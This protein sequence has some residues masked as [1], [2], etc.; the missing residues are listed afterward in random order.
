MIIP[1]KIPVAT[2]GMSVLAAML[3][4]GYQT[5]LGEWADSR[6]VG[7]FQLR[8]EFPL[9][10]ENGKQ[11]LE[12][13]G[14]LQQDVETLLNLKAGTNP[15]EVNL[16]RTRE[17][18]RDYLSQ[19]VPEG[20]SRP[21]LFVKSNDIGRVYVYRHWGFEKDVRHECTHAVLHNAL[22]YV[23]L[24]IDEG[25]AEYFEVPRSDRN[26]G[27]PHLSELKRRVYF[28]W[29]PDLQKLE[30]L[31]SLQD[32]D[33]DDYRDSW[34]V[35]HFLLHGPQEVRQILADYLYDIQAG[36]LAGKLSDRLNARVP[37]FDA[38]VTAHIR[39]WK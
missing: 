15:I 11:L 5:A 22:P 39:H 23:P 27:N 38:H 32:M 34:A 35:V 10:D 19:R 13:M 31:G 21:A 7:P 36:N 30:T 17:N 9:S 12:E 4:L 33:A 1:L 25:F 2:C 18:Y 37:N 20:M 26:R 29:Q 6:N 24:W 14:K 28:G 3:V 16:F 8:S